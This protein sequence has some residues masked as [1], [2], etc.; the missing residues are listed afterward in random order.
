MLF[1]SNAENIESVKSSH[2]QADALIRAVE[3]A[4]QASLKAR[5]QTPDIIS[6]L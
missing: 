5:R 3:L 6:R 1:L 2:R 4:R